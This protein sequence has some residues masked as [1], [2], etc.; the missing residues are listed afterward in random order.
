MTRYL[1]RQYDT[2]LS[3]NEDGDL[4]IEQKDDYGEVDLVVIS[5]SNIAWFKDLVDLTVSDGYQEESDNGM[6]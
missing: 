3:I 1:T 5:A 2:R 6:V 4:Y